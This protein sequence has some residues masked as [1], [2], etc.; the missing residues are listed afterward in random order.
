MDSDTSVKDIKDTLRELALI[1]M[2][3]VKNDTHAAAGAMA[4]EVVGR[5]DLV[6]VLVHEACLE[7]CE[8][9]LTAVRSRVWVAPNQN[10]QRLAKAAKMMRACLYD[11]PIAGGRKLGDVTPEELL[12]YGEHEIKSG[13]TRIIRGQFIVRVAREATP[14]KPIRKSVTAKRL[15]AIKADIEKEFHNV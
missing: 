2:A 1:S 14:G 10:G 3:D 9:V 13:R 4:A 6:D 15:D 7:C 5:A 8:M 11:Y 12:P